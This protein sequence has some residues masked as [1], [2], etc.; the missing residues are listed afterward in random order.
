[1]QNKIADCIILIHK[2]PYNEVLELVKREIQVLEKPP[3]NITKAVF[4][5]EYEN[6]IDSYYISGGQ[7]QY[8][9]PII[10]EDGWIKAGYTPERIQKHKENAIIQRKQ[11]VEK[12]NLEIIRKL[13]KQEEW[14]KKIAR[15]ILSALQEKQ[16]EQKQF[17]HFT[18]SFTAYQIP[19]EIL[20]ALE[21]NGCITQNPL[22]WSK[23]K[24]LF[25]YFVVCMCEKFNL[26]HGQNRT[27]K[28]F[29]SCFGISG[30]SGIINDIKKVGTPPAD[31]EIINDILK[32]KKNFFNDNFLNNK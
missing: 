12:Y 10:N 1:L 29:E 27:L 21:Q 20:Q 18:R 32:M 13:R 2:Q 14:V 25:A 19:P 26:K 11:Y 4:L 22:Q 30:L 31:Y 16:P 24:N 28:P 15:K 8:S 7:M 23:E 17:P 5:Q 6:N 9:E 3:Y